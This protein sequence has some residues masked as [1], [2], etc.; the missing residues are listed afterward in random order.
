MT[1]SLGTSSLGTVDQRQAFGW[2]SMFF[3]VWIG[4]VLV[5]S[6]PGLL[7]GE[8]SSGG[9]GDCSRDVPKLLLPATEE[10]WWFQAADLR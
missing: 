9:G 6:L 3:L 7:R 10:R 5:P 1:S 2:S 4:P 8:W